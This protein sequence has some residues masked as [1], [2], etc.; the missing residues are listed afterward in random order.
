MAR[1]YSI[2]TLGQFKVIKNDVQRLE[3]VIHGWMWNRNHWNHNNDDDWNH[4]RKE[5]KD[6]KKKQPYNQQQQQHHKQQQQQHRVL[7]SSTI[8]RLL[9]DRATQSSSLSSSCHKDLLYRQTILQFCKSNKELKYA[10]KIDDA[11]IRPLIMDEHDS[12]R[13]YRNSVQILYNRLSQILSRRFKGSHLSVYGSCLSGLS[14]GHSSDVDLSLYIP[15]AEKL[16]Q[17]KSTM[18]EK[19]FQKK[20]KKFVYAVY[21]CI[22]D[23]NRNHGRNH[24][25]HRHHHHHHHEP[26]A[27]EFK[28]M[29][30]VLLHV[31]QLSR[32][33]IS[34]LEIHSARM[35]PYTLIYA[36]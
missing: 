34:T 36:S 22:Q 3:K 32:G 20:M 31:Y 17:G 19:A 21:G 10:R 28:D 5:K 15:E 8:P 6:K 35:V 2:V 27:V 26:V 25:N 7:A 9:I 14:L 13:L 11:I 23:E 4:G 1:A 12:H 29:Q 16:L 30:A 18:D 24:Y 33:G